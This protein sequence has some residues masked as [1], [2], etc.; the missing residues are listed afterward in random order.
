MSPHRV[1]C[2]VVI[3]GTLGC[4]RSDRQAGADTRADAA[5][6]AVV[7]QAAATLVARFLGC[8]ELD[9]D[10]GQRYQVYLTRSRMGPAW[11]AIRYGQDSRNAPG[12]QW[13][14]API[15]ST[16]FRL[17]WGGI[18][19]TMEFT[20]TRQESGYAASGRLRDSR[21][22]PSGTDLHATLR[23]VECPSPTA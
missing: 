18:D 22:R 4:T 9:V 2:L 6:P 5:T 23:S 21:E 12:D 17:E 14:W 13:S 10:G 16:H 3:A 8:Y 19:S 11:V 20:M 15:D 1:M 7:P